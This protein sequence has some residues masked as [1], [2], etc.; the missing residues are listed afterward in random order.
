MVNKK[1]MNGYHS[2]VGKSYSVDEDVGKEHLDKKHL[3]KMNLDKKNSDEA[4]IKKT[5][6]F[7][8]KTLGKDTTGHDWWHVYRVWKMALYIAEREKPNNLMIVQLGALLHDIADWK[9]NDG[10]DEVG[11]EIAERWLKRNGVENSVVNSV[12]DI[13]RNISFKGAMVKN[14]MK[15]KEGLIVQDAD[16]LDAIG[17][18]GIAR[19]FA[20]GGSKG[21]VM[22]DPM[23][24]FHLHRS[25]EDYK[26]NKGSTINH[27]YEKLLLLKD[28]MNTKTA[29]KIAEERDQFMR[30]FL[31][32]FFEE[33]NF[34]DSIEY[35]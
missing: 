18:I 20:Y 19:A 16:R 17:A 12:V 1:I 33:W 22:Y 11:P 9:F 31:D 29:R 21:R 3:D 23:M 6:E 35:F 34:P 24:K 25:F 5:V 26:K 2:F 30:V 7:V 15:L 13:V 14:S 28:R 10:N 4:I 8:R 27:F 32:K